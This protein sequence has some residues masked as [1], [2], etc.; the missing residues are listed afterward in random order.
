M[1]ASVGTAVTR[2]HLVRAEDVELTPALPDRSRGLTRAV[3]VG[4]AT[5]SV[6]TGLMLVRL[7]DGHV[8]SHLHSFE[9]SFYV[10]TGN[11]VLY[12]D[13]R[14]LRLE[15]DACGAI[16]VGVPHAFR[17]EGRAEW[18]EMLSPRP[19]GRGEAISIQRA[20][21]SQ[22]QACAMPTGIAPHASG[23]RRRPRPSR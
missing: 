3:L 2:H 8:D 5:G 10:L 13:G 4:G 21:P 17:S 11:P 20:S 7:E 14:G 9:S 15:P 18:I 12:L 6:H 23:S 19:R 1:D 16:P 22:R